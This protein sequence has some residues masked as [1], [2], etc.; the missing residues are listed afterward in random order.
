MSIISLS[1][2]YTE[3]W[4]IENAYMKNVCNKKKTI[5]ILNFC[6]ICVLKFNFPHEVLHICI[7]FEAHSGIFKVRTLLH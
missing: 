2:K 1:L 3:F 5:I 4:K 6:T 7:A